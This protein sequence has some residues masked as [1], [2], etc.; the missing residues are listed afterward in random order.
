MKR[1]SI[2]CPPCEYGRS[3]YP[4]H[5]DTC[6]FVNKKCRD[7]RECPKEMHKI[8]LVSTDEDMQEIIRRAKAGDKV[9]LFLLRGAE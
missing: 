1:Q 5:V 6:G 9:A 3:T 8:N 4:G 7:L 2:I